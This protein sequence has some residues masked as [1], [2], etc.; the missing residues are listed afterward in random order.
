MLLSI[1]KNLISGRSLVFVNMKQR[2]DQVME[3]RMLELSLDGTPD[4]SPSEDIHF[5]PEEMLPVVGNVGED[6]PKTPHVSRGCDV[7]TFSENLGSQVADSSAIRGGVVV[8]GR[9]GLAW[10][11]N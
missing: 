6:S 7:T 1:L 8:H 4:S 5:G 9:G 2:L 3:L 10:T 11:G